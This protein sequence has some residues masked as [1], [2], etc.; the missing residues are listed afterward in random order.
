[1]LAGVQ[2]KSVNGRKSGLSVDIIPKAVRDPE[3]DI[4]SRAY[5]TGSLE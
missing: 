1:M 5:G 3:T 2:R 4:A